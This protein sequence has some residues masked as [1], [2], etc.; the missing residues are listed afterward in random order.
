M[1]VHKN[2][3]VLPYLSTETT[4]E[5]IKIGVGFRS[6]II[7]VKVIQL[8]SIC[9]VFT[10]IELIICGSRLSHNCTNKFVLG[11]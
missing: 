2:I 4:T 1:L 5:V 11:Y 3:A 9:K 6:I 10:I 7:N 8:L